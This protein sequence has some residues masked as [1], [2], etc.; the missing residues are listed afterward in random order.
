[1]QAIRVTFV[2]IWQKKAAATRIIANKTKPH[3]HI[4]SPTFFVGV[5]YLCNSAQCKGF[6]FRQTT[7]ES[8]WQIVIMT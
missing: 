4:E 5:R 6:L 2:R 7:S 8:K 1:L 3:C